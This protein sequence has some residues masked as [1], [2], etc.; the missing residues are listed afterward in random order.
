MLQLKPDVRAFRYRQQG[1]A[2]LAWN[3]SASHAFKAQ[4]VDDQRHVVRP[5][6]NA[7]PSH[8]LQRPS[9]NI[10]EVD[11]CKARD[12]AIPAAQTTRRSCFNPQRAVGSQKRD[13]DY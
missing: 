5:D 9:Q 10:T 2:S 7:V 8:Q 12:D 4:C 6:S 1:A 11:P 13:L 3:K